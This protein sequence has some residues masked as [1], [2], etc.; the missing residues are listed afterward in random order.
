MAG[1]NAELEE[2][3][4][5]RLLEMEQR[6]ERKAEAIEKTYDSLQTMLLKAEAILNTIQQ[7]KEG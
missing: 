5:Y 4:Y 3:I 2:I 7:I 1:Q 6:L